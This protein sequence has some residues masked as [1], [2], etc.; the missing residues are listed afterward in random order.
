MNPYIKAQIDN[1][2]AT[3]RMFQKSCELAASQDDGTI[4]KEEAKMLK[5]INKATDRFI[6]DISNLA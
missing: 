3:A 1:I 6:K 5:A 4:S 2:T